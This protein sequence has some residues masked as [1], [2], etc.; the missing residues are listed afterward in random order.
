VN[1]NNSNND[2]VERFP[3]FFISNRKK[4]KWSRIAE[5]QRVR[6]RERESERQGIA[7]RER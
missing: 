3:R 2:K 1:L 7:A 6:E 5:R 4:G